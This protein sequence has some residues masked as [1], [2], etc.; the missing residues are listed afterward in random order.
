MKLAQRLM[1]AAVLL[2]FSA[3]PVAADSTL[4]QERQSLPGASL[5]AAVANIFYVPVRF[6]VTA[7]SA[8]L[9]GLTGFLTGGNKHAAEDVWGMFE[10]QAILTRNAVQGLEPV[11]FGN[12]EHR[13]L[14]ISPGY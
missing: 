13:L 1:M 2:A 14:L 7:V 9:G 11:R 12:L 4:P 10:G 8:E 3:F 5:T 6:A